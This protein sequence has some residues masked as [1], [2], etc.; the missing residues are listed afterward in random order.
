MGTTAELGN[1]GVCCTDKPP[2]KCSVAATNVK[3]CGNNMVVSG[4]A[5]C[6]AW[7]CGAGDFS[8]DKQTCC[9][10]AQKCL[11]AKEAAKAKAAQVSGAAAAAPTAALLL[12][13]TALS[14]RL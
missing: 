9:I 4:T 11:A 12:I 8:G 7:S 6:A 14:F 3:S 1:G 13:A 5:S 2:Q 10:M